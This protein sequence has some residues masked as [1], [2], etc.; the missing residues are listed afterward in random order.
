MPMTLGLETAHR[1]RERA[2]SRFLTRPLM[3]IV[4]I[5]LLAGFV[6]ALLATLGMAQEGAVRG[7][8]D[9]SVIKADGTYYL[10]ST[11]AG[12]PIRSSRDLRHWDRAGRVFAVNPSWFKEAVPGSNWIWAPDISRRRGT[13]WLYYSVST[14]GSNRSCIGLA[15]NATLDPSSPDYQVGGSGAGDQ[16]AAG[17]RLERHRPEPRARPGRAALAGLRFLLER[18]QA[19][20]ARPGLRQAA[21][22]GSLSSSRWPRAGRLVRSRRLFSCLTVS[23]TISSSRSTT[24]A[25]VWTAITR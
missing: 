16:L 7:V 22:R 1:T 17:G 15:T 11:G 14:F 10:F 2:V 8:H 19:R 23:S 5:V 21:S 20:T 12:I 18:D 13:Y 4:R 24:A 25:G 3:S 9:P 6:P